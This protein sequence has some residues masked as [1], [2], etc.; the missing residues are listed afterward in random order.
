MEI[1]LRTL[2]PLWT[3]GVD[4]TP[5]R[6]HETGLIGSLRWWYEA[7]VRGLGGYACDPTSEVPEAR[8]AFD[9]KAYEHAKDK[10]QSEAEAIKAGLHQVCPVCYL[11]GT[12]GWARLFQLRSIGEVSTTSLHF[13]TTLKLNR[14]WLQ[15]VL[16]GQ[17]KSLEGKKIPYGVLRFQIIPRRHDAEYAITQLALILRFA[18]DYGGIGAKTQYGFGQFA[19]IDGVSESVKS[20]LQALQAKIGAGFLR[21]TGPTI[22]TPFDL[23]HFVSL[24]YRISQNALKDFLTDAAHLGAEEKKSESNYIPCVFDLRYRGSGKG[25]VLGLRAW[26][27]KQGWTET[28]DPKNLGEIDML[29]GSRSRWGNPEQQQAVDEDVRTGSR[30]FFGMPYKNQKDSDEYTLRVWAFWPP[31]LNPKVKNPQKLSV[32]LKSYLQNLFGSVQPTTE[33]VGREWLTQFKV[34]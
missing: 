14:N 10:G 21:S 32:L 7:L 29:L 20:G 34:R 3:G 28:T 8:C 25:K 17:D 11:F 33:M 1:R 30:V 15:N 31:E 13:R 12:T 16:G 23:N 9:T 2:T 18:A 22:S 4:R 6:L 26:L 19:L 24:T 5:D 27:K